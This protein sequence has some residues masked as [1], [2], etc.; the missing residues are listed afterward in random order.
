MFSWSRGS[1][2][3]ALLFYF[4]GRKHLRGTGFVEHSELFS[5]KAYFNSL[6]ADADFGVSVVYSLFRNAVVQRLQGRGLTEAEAAYCFG[7]AVVDMAHLAEQEQDSEAAS[8]EVFLEQLSYAHARIRYGAPENEVLQV[9][10]PLNEEV[11]RSTQQKAMVWSALQQID[12]IC[13]EALLAGA[14]DPAEPCAQALQRAL[15]EEHPSTEML[16]AALADKTGFQIWQHAEVQEKTWKR[17]SPEKPA[18]EQAGRNLWR[19]AVLA[20]V[21]IAAAYAGYQFYFRP[22]TIAELYA[23]YFSPPSSL[24][25]DWEQRNQGDTLATEL[26]QERCLFLLQKADA[27]YKIGSYREAMDPLLLIVLDTT[28]PCRSDAWL[29]LGLIQLHLKDPTTAIQCF[30]KI[31]DFERFGEDIYWYQVMAYL[32]IAENTPQQRERVA[33]AVELAIPNL[34]TPARRARAEALLKNLSP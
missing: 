33:K 9:P 12:P 22:K 19:W 6:R 3:L 24:I 27:F 17:P 4:Y 28:A 21:G 16:Q 8:V 2:V 34:H 23:S 26:F 10:P 1:N 31:E 25:T 18:V 5:N 29:Y 30:A 15:P 14:T 11:L 13:R 32:Q 7:L 20:L